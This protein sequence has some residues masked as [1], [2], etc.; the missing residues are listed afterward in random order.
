M[1]IAIPTCK[2]KMTLPH[3]TNHRTTESSKRALGRVLTSESFGKNPAIWDSLAS[4]GFYYARPC[5]PHCHLPF[6]TRQLREKL[7]FSAQCWKCQRTTNLL[8][9]TKLKGIRKLRLF[10]HATITWVS[11]GKVTTMMGE[12]GIAPK[13]WASFK[14]RLQETVNE[15]LER[16]A[17]S[18]DLKLGGPGKV[19]EVDECKLYSPKNH[20]GH[21]PA[22]N[23]IWAVGLIERDKEGGRRSA[24]KLT[25]KRS[26]SELVPFIKECDHEGSILISDEWK[27]YTKELE[28][29]TGS[30]DRGTPRSLKMKIDSNFLASQPCGTF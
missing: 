13:T 29:Y 24:F 18:G 6:N 1:T 25:E 2:M 15:T 28:K 30:L 16:L 11:N 12:S 5:C 23:D 3:G 8:E 26:A 9:G 14:E 17:H 21:P 10:L 19:V 27:G 20:R 4:M 7:R 22:G